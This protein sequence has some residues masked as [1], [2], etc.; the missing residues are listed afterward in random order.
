MQVYLFLFMVDLHRAMIDLQ[1]E[2]LCSTIFCEFILWKYG[3]NGLNTEFSV[4]RESSSVAKKIVFS[5]LKNV[6]RG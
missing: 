2:K 4:L 1:V 5:H 6:Q 3:N